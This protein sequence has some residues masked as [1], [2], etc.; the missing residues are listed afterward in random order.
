MQAVS[1]RPQQRLLMSKRIA[2]YALVVLIGLVPALSL[3]LTMLLPLFICPLINGKK[4]WMAWI[5]VPL[6]SVI[7]LL[8]GYHPAYAASLL[9]VTGLPAMVTWRMNPVQSSKPESIL[10]YV[11]V[12]ALALGFALWALYLDAWQESVGLAEFLSEKVEQWVM[13]H[14]QRTSLLY[15]AMSTGL[16]PVPEG[17]QQVTLLNLTIDP[18]FLSE[19]R[20]MLRTRVAQLVETK[21]PTLLVQASILLG[22]FIDLRILRM[23]GSYLLLNKEEPNKVSIALAPSFSRLRMPRRWRVVLL[24]CCLSYFFTIGFQGFGYRLGQ[25]MYAAFETA[26]RLQGA[27]VIC[28]LIMGE[29]QER[30]VLAGIAAGLLFVMMPFAA[31][32]AGC[33][34]N[35]FSFR[36][37]A[38]DDKKEREKNEEEKP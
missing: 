22:V 5:A 1:L 9:L 8:Y 26:Y 3:P 6:P 13:T 31:F 19:V 29:K 17:Y 16:L 36:L 21:V 4:N 27:A 35:V 2:L 32:L 30:R 11:A 12:M 15:R 20:L 18:V 33:F 10:M 34:E 28:S 25:L 23:W 24:I 14:P 38:E 7:V 37:R